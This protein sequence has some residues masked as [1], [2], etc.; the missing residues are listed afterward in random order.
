MAVE[1]LLIGAVF[2][3]YDLVVFYVFFEGTLIPMF[4]VI[5]VWGG[6]EEKVQAAYYFFLY[7]FSGSVL[8]LLGLV[9]LYGYA[10][11]GTT[12]YQALCSVS[13]DYEVQVYVFV[14]LYIGL[15]VKLPQ[16]PFHI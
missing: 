12:D 13:L 14:C 16:M 3:V 4:I 8:M 5:G 15:A 9:A 2:S 11:A 7:T 1:A 10:Y 6:R